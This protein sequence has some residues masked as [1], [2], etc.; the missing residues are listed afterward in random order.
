MSRRVARNTQASPSA[1]VAPELRDL[2]LPQRLFQRDQV[3]PVDR[4]S[5][6]DGLHVRYPRHFEDV[7]SGAAS[8]PCSPVCDVAT[9]HA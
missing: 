8:R 7:V 2:T 1:G 9:A 6:R 3:L 5:G 4:D